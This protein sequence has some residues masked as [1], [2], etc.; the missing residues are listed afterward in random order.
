MPR[1]PN[2][3]LRVYDLTRSIIFYTDRIGFTLVEHR[4]EADIA[5]LLDSDGD[6]NLLAGPAAADLAPYVAERHLLLKPGN[7]ITFLNN[8]LTAVRSALLQRDFENIEIVQ[9]RFGDSMLCI[10]DPD[11]YILRFITPSAH[12][13]AEILALYATAPNELDAALTGLSETDLNL[14]QAD[15][16]WTIRQIVHHLADN[17][18]LYLQW[19]KTA[20][21]QGSIYEQN[22][23]A[24]NDIIARTL[25]Y[26]QRPIEPSVALFRTIR[27]HIVQL[28]QFIPDYGERYTQDKEGHRYTFIRLLEI[29]TRHAIEHIDEICQIRDAHT[30]PATPINTSHQEEN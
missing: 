7:T 9:T 23:T 17:D 29:L 21:A 6:L 28:T 12:S 16:T 1:L 30:T 26:T 24:G 27:A 20:L 14:S 19:M 5:Y 22:W 3:A 13:P 2:L 25:A 4:P 11:G 15:G 18:C 8:D 10:Q